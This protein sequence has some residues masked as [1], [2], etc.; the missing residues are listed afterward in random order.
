[1]QLSSYLFFRHER[2]RKRWRV[3]GYPWKLVGYSW[4]VYGPQKNPSQP[5][6]CLVPSW[7]PGTIYR[8]CWELLLG[9]KGPQ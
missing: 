4:A 8:F 9:S 2:T 5:R 1:M 7:V 3:V 6:A